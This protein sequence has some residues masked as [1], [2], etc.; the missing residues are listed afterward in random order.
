MD[1]RRI[2]GLGKLDELVDDCAVGS[3]L[4]LV[5]QQLQ[6]SG[7]SSG[8]YFDT[9]IREIPNP[10]V[11]SES[12]RPLAREPAETDTLHD[13][14]HSDVQISHAELCPGAPAHVLGGALQP[15]DE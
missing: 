8:Q 13:A 15:V 3:A 12:T 11:E 7:L 10:A 4:K 9:A 6:L 2:P 5:A 14:S 1:N